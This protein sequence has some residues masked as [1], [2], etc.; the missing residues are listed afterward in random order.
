MLNW[1]LPDKSIRK[2]ILTNDIEPNVTTNKINEFNA[3]VLKNSLTYINTNK[4]LKLSPCNYQ[5]LLEAE[6]KHKIRITENSYVEKFKIKLAE[7]DVIYHVGYLHYLYLAY[8]YNY[9]IVVGPEHI[10]NIILYNIKDKILIHPNR[11]IVEEITTLN[12]IAINNFKVEQDDYKDSLYSLFVPK[13]KSFYNN[14][15]I[16]DDGKITKIS[17]TGEYEQWL[18]LRN[19]INKLYYM[20]NKDPYLYKVYYVVNNM[21]SNLHVTSYWQNFFVIKNGYIKGYIAD[22]FDK[23]LNQIE[24]IASYIDVS[25]SNQE[26]R[27]SGVLYSNI[28]DDGFLIPCYANIKVITYID[29][30]TLNRSELT[31]REIV[32]KFIKMF[33]GYSEVSWTLLKAIDHEKYANIMLSKKYETMFLIKHW[34]IISERLSINYIVELISYTYNMNIYNFI[35]KHITDADERLEIQFKLMWVLSESNLLDEVIKVVYSKLCK[36]QEDY[37]R[38]HYYVE[39]QCLLDI[40]TKFKGK[41]INMFGITSY[42][43][44]LYLGV[45]QTLFIEK[46]LVSLKN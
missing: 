41:D 31:N 23:S 8:R 36:D 15:D 12:V 32:L 29:L 6:L 2:H 1:I 13:Q 7:Q 21:W 28:S 19:L 38:I 11:E 30:C 4:Q 40:K 18:I 26:K 3:I 17:V 22:L 27:L 44:L 25:E 42:H 14:I 45:N 20:L 24:N 16:K 5:A 37:N 46:L 33:I 39:N 34:K 35:L 10:W 43:M 9:G